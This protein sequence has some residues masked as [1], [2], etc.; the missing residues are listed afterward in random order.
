MLADRQLFFLLSAGS[1]PVDVGKGLIAVLLPL[2]DLG[3]LV[4]IAH[5]VSLIVDW[6][7]WSQCSDSIAFQRIHWPKP[8]A[9]NLSLSGA[10]HIRLVGATGMTGVLSSCYYCGHEYL[11]SGVDSG[12]HTLL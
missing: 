11:H 10:S 12:L 9:L 4:G 8:V 2:P 3:G 7:V 1:R 5:E 6:R